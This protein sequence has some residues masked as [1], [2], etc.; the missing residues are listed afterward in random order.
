MGL[1]REKLR[2]CHTG[3]VPRGH[4]RGLSPKLQFRHR[5]SGGWSKLP[6]EGPGGSATRLL[7]RVTRSAAEPLDEVEDLP[8]PGD[9][10]HLERPGDE[11]A[12]P[13][14]LAEEAL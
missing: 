13:E 8:R 10:R 9:V 11:R 7:A 12:V 4:V 6:T 5:S 3:H 1:R 14:E 2:F